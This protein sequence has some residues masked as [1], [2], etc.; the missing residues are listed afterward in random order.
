MKGDQLNTPN[1]QKYI[2]EERYALNLPDF[3]KPE[4]SEVKAL[5]AYLER[6]DKLPAIDIKYGRCVEATSRL[7]IEGCQ[8]EPCFSFEL[9]LTT[10]GY[11]PHRLLTEFYN[12]IHTTRSQSTQISENVITA[13]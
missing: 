9:H 7:L 5:D 12:A 10:R 6:A 11:E 3:K 4:L 13:L 1:K 8:P 2:S